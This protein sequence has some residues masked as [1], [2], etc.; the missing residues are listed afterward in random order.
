MNEEEWGLLNINWTGW[1]N[2]EYI[3]DFM[4]PMIEATLA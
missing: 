4:K 2:E 1:R 3:E